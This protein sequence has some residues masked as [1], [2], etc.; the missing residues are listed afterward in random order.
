VYVGPEVIAG[1]EQRFGEP[2]K[3]SFRVD[4]AP[5]EIAFIRRT[6]KHGR[7][8]DVT[9]VIADGDRFAVIAKHSYPSGLF[10]FPSGGLSPGETLE[11]GA[12]REGREETG[13]DLELTRYLLRA[14]VRFRSTAGDDAI[15]WTTHVFQARV[16]GGRLEPLDTGEIR[17]AA[18]LGRDEL[19]GPI[20]EVLSGRP[21]AGLRYRGWL[22]D[23]VFAVL[24]GAAAPEH[25][26][27]A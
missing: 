25:G 4:T 20:R 5:A 6:Q 27:A 10:R 23:A 7:A 2:A 15:D 26:G 19:L 13:L 1:A 24:D 9:L 22:Q 14:Q 21:E 18:W 8:H 17:E 12:L 16:T 3:R 11:E